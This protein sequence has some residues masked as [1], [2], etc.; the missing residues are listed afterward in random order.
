MNQIFV[1]NESTNNIKSAADIFKHTQEINIDH[2]R[3]HFI[4]IQ[5]DTHLV[6]IKSEILFIG[7]ISEATID[8]R[9]VFKHL[10]ESGAVRFAIAHNHPS[11][12]LTSSASDHHIVNKLQKIGALLNIKLIDSIIFNK[13]EFYSNF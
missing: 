12:N 6:P 7:G 5:F 3:E 4:L 13:T 1:I 8:V 2:E 9:I 10:L 11:G